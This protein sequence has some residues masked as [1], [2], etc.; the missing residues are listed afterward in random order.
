VLMS[1]AKILR[2]NPD[3]RMMIEGHTDN[4][5]TVDANVDLSRR[6]AEAVRQAL[7]GRYQIDGGRLTSAGYGASRPRAGN[8]TLEG[9]AANR[10][11]ELVRS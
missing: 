7:V 8:D 4:I 6:R 2:S 11:V 5:G 3:W 9:R 1:I 10:R